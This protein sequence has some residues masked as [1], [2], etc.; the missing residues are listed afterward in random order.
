MII[1]QRNCDL[2]ESLLF[3]LENETGSSHE[4]MVYIGTLEF[5]TETISK[6]IPYSQ[7]KIGYSLT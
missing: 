3:E 7:Q 4:H 6:Y 1:Q 2:K 5:N